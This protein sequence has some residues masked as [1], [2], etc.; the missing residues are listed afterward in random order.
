M[1]RTVVAGGV[2]VGVLIGEAGIALRSGVMTA[3]S[4]RG[5]AAP[6]PNGLGIVRLIGR[7]LGRPGAALFEEA[8]DLGREGQKNKRN[9]GTV[10]RARET[11]RELATDKCGRKK[12]R[13]A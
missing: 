8:S 6:A 3:S 2:H 7:G 10:H 12:D 1:E 11:A 4:S 13:K 9:V 5:V